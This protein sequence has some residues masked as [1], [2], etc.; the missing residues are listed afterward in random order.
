MN[1]VFRRAQKLHDTSTEWARNEGCKA[2]EQKWRLK[3]DHYRSNNQIRNRKEHSKCGWKCHHWSPGK[4]RDN[5]NKFKWLR[6]RLKEL[7]EK[8]ITAMKER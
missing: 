1:S 5:F 3:Y 7:E 2:K 8:K 4:T 6:K